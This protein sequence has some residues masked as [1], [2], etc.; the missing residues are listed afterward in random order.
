MSEWM[1]LV[2]KVSKENPGKPLKEVLKLAKKEYKKSKPSNVT[3]KVTKKSH[4]KSKPSKS[5]KKRKAKKALK[6]SSKK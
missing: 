3:K 5:V 4:K 2:K 6:R 1:N